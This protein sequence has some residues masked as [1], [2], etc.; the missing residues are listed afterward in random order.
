MQQ[1]VIFL[2]TV[3]LAQPPGTPCLLRKADLLRADVQGFRGG[4][5]EAGVREGIVT[6]DLVGRG[7]EDVCLV[8]VV[9]GDLESGTGLS[10]ASKTST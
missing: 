7:T 8:G 5:H 2:D 1:V 10:A 6:A 3:K 9:L 4:T